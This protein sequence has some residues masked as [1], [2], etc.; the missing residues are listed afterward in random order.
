MK[1]FAAILMIFSL[2]LSMT[3]CGD[4]KND[5]NMDSAIESAQPESSADVENTAEPA[6]T[7]KAE[8]VN[9][10]TGKDAKKAETPATTPKPAKPEKPAQAAEAAPAEKTV[11]L[12]ACKASMTSSLA[13]SDVSDISSGRL[14]DMYGI[15]SSQVKQSASFVAASGGAFPMEV[16]MIEAVDEA[17]AKNIQAKL[18]QRAAAI[19]EQASSY[20]PDSAALAKSCPITQSGVYVAMFF[21]PKQ[22]QMQ[23]IFKNFIQ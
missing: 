23:S 1:K 4:K 20:D 16:V 8:A 6:E 3:A 11:D 2:M 19:E 15:S 18:R 22:S 9:E 10:D 12:A 13:L 5:E 17:Q 21:S 7:E 14:L